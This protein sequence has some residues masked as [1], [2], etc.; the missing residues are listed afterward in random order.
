VAFKIHRN[1]FP[2]GALLRTSLGGAHGAPPD[3]LVDCE[4][5]IFSRLQPSPRKVGAFG[6]S[7]GVGQIFSSRRARD[8]TPHFTKYFTTTVANVKPAPGGK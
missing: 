1:A 8:G 6:V 3:S 2:A 7:V 5:T 4:G